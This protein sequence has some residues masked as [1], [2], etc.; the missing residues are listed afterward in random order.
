MQAF[1]PALATACALVIAAVA[2]P[3][4]AKDWDVRA[5]GRLLYDDGSGPK[6]VAG[7][8]VKVMDADTDFDD[9]LGE[10][11]TDANGNFNVAG[12]G[13]D[14]SLP[15]G[16]C[17]DNC[18]K[19]D[20]Y[21]SVALR[22]DRVEIET[23]IGFTWH[24]NTASRSNTAGDL[25]FGSFKFSSTDGGHAGIL[26][27][28][29]IQQYDHYTSLVGGRIP[30]HDGKI[31][32]LFPALLA[33][34]VPWTTEESIHWPGG[35]DRWNAVFHEFGHRVRHAADGDFAHFLYDVARF[36]YTQQ[37]R[38]EM[39]SN[40]GF[41]FNEGFA[42]YHA[43][44][45]DPHENTT[46]AHWGQI[47][48][49][50]EIEGNVAAKLK[51]LSDACGGFKNVW[52]SLTSASIHS[53]GELEG[54]MKR[55]F[56]SCF[57][58]K[59]QVH[60]NLPLVKFVP[61]A[62]EKQTAVVQALAAT[63]GAVQPVIHLKAAARNQAA[64][65]G[66]QPAFAR[67]MAARSQTHRVV[68]KAAHDA[69]RKHMLAFRPITF[70]TAKSGEFLKQRQAARHGFIHD[71][72]GPQLAEVDKLLAHVKVERAAASNAGLH[73][74]LD[75]LK[76]RYEKRAAELRKALAAPASAAMKIPIHLLPRSFGGAVVA[77]R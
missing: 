77:V 15:F 75:Y 49:G 66:Q 30:R 61:H 25:D 65:A 18:T 31:N 42:E 59:V 41:A 74:H 35:E 21:V 53:Y 48:G 12:R 14:P 6:P 51:H 43:T 34:G 8:K 13:G 24:A 33:A 27:A 32:I 58:P 56:P 73:K 45:L 63:V 40:L 3:S 46:F 22:N 17:D 2:P 38:Y 37:H 36:T 64:F 20:P 60:P 50:D 57:I 72:L 52:A 69:F 76:A 67:L 55:K 54:A 70:E 4:L 5:R 10:G 11:W 29:T 1:R 19:P 47:A 71:A 62:I 39:K 23:E 68:A 16:I 26:F 7:A 9:T 28:R 44:L